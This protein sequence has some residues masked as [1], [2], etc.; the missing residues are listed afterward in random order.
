MKAPKI[1]GMTAGV[2]FVVLIITTFCI[3]REDA[4][5][6]TQSMGDRNVAIDMG[7]GPVRYGTQKEHDLHQIYDEVGVISIFAGIVSLM[8]GSLL[9][10]K[11]RNRPN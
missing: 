3:Y 9:Q 10:K 5:L 11:S 6:P 7:K 2:A 4:V 8:I 1:Y